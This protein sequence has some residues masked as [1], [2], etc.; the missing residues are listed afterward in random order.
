MLKGV[1]QK[2][3]LAEHGKCG[4]CGK[5]EATR[6]DRMCDSCRFSVTLEAITNEKK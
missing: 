5:R 2:Q 4:K 1:L 6:E 3:E